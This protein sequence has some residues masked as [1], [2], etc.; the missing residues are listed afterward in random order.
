LKVE[1]PYNTYLHKGLPPGPIANPGRA[2]IEA[3]VK[4]ASHDYF[5]YVTK[6]D[7]SSEHYFSRTLKEHDARD[8]QSRSNK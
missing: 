6:K 7:G 8:A 1:S 2:S 5:F 3:V 4:P